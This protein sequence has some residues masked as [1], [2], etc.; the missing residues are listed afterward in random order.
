M[1]TSQMFACSLQKPEVTNDQRTHI[2][3]RTHSYL[4]LK[5]HARLHRIKQHS[6]TNAASIMSLYWFNLV[7]S[8]L[9]FVAVALKRSTA[10]CWR[11]A[12]FV[13]TARNTARAIAMKL[14]TNTEA[15]RQINNSDYLS[16]RQ[17]A[18]RCHR[19][20]EISSYHL[21]VGQFTLHFLPLQRIR[22]SYVS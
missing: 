7:F 20:R 17:S 6:F 8:L 19:P 13:V 10:W 14:R 1:M 11:R 3:W 16:H 15:E 18:T 21:K 12:R 5:I 4:S 9:Q 22:T 2:E